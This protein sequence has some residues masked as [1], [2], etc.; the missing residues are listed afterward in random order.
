V[1]LLLLLLAA[2]AASSESSAFL[3]KFYRFSC[4]CRYCLT[5]NLQRQSK[6]KAAHKLNVPAKADASTKRKQIPH[7]NVASG[8]NL[9]LPIFVF[10]VQMISFG[11]K[12]I[13]TRVAQRKFVKFS[14]KNK[15]FHGKKSFN[16]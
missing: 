11:S 15:L 13:I 3:R 4:C 14:H 6:K 12:N 7:A 2:T 16:T 5:N 9:E 8:P 1:L 10:R